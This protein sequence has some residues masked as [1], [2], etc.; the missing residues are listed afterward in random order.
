MERCFSGTIKD[1]SQIGG[2]CLSG[3]KK[4]AGPRLGYSCIKPHGR[5]SQELE[6]RVARVEAASQ[7]GHQSHLERDSRYKWLC[8]EAHLF[9]PLLCLVFKISPPQ[10]VWKH[11]A[12]ADLRYESGSYGKWP[13]KKWHFFLPLTIPFIPLFLLGLTGTQTRLPA[14]GNSDLAISAY[15]CRSPGPGKRGRSERWEEARFQL[16][17]SCYDKINEGWSFI[18]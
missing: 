17:K 4:K 11:I 2:Q 16:Q 15:S 12:H 14:E 6:Q 1:R 8:I 3:T 5:G 18:Q 13:S 10:H 7:W 9:S